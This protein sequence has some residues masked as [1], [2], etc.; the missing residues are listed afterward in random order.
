[1]EQENGCVFP[2][3]GLPLCATPFGVACSLCPSTSLRGQRDQLAATGPCLRMHMKRRHPEVL[4]GWSSRAEWKK[5]AETLTAARAASAMAVSGSSNPAALLKSCTRALPPSTLVGKE[6]LVC[7][8]CCV[9]FASSGSLSDHR[10]TCHV[11]KGFGRRVPRDDLA[12]SHPGGALVSLRVFNGP[13]P[14]EG[15]FCA[16][17]AGPTSVEPLQP[18]RKKRIPPLSAAAEDS[19]EARVPRKKAKKKSSPFDWTLPEQTTVDRV[20]RTL[21]TDSAAMAECIERLLPLAQL[22]LS[23]GVS[24]HSSKEMLVAYGNVC[25]AFFPHPNESEQDGEGPL[26]LALLKEKGRHFRDMTV[27]GLPKEGVLSVVENNVLYIPLVEKA[28]QLW[29]R[30]CISTDVLSRCDP[31]LRRKVSGWVGGSFVFFFRFISGS[32]SRSPPQ[33]SWGI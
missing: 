5:W 25:G 26:T 10:R 13:L 24:V 32:R 29:Y 28:A 15:R 2:V 4:S 22:V 19:S 3:E 16:L 12:I 18:Y 17:V 30:W 9:V 21:G 7:S 27:G 6:Y 8:E 20:G 31:A 23:P 33:M 1:M 11:G 14:P